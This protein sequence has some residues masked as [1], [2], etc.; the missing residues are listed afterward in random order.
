MDGFLES[1]KQAPDA[2]TSEGIKAICSLDVTVEPN[3]AS[4]QAFEESFWIRIQYL[5]FPIKGGITRAEVKVKLSEGWLDITSI[6]F[7]ATYSA[8]FESWRFSASAFTL[9]VVNPHIV[10]MSVPTIIEATKA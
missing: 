8:M 7:V 2:E 6:L 4:T 3:P 1:L 5:W 9:A 10:M